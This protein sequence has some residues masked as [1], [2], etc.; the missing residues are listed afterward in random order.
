MQRQQ[1]HAANMK[2][3]ALFAAAQTELQR[4]TLRLMSSYA[5][6][7]IAS[8][9]YAAQ[10]RVKPPPAGSGWFVRITSPAVG[11]NA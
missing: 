2:L 6:R 10:R 9:T 1:Q 4:H 11:L 8:R 7:Q 5:H 3:L